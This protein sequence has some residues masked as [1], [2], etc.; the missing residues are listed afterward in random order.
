MT[1]FRF[2]VVTLVVLGLGGA[3]SRRETTST[4]STQSPSEAP[5]FAELSA[6]SVGP[7]GRIVDKEGRDVLLR[8]VNITSLGDYYQ[9]DPDNPPTIALTDEDWTQME[10]YGVSVVRL[11]IHWSLIEPTRGN[12]D[13]SYLDRISQAVDAAQAH[14]IYTV[15]DMHQDAYTATI[16]TPPGQTCPSG[17]KPAVGWD[18]APAWAT[19]TDG[20]STCTPDERNAS[21]A[22]RAAWNHFWENSRGIRDRFV[23]AWGAVAQR[24]AGRTEVAGYDV[25][26]EPE[27]S[28]PA[29]ELTPLYDALVKDSV[30]AIRSAEAA[31]GPPHL[32]FVEP[33]IPAGDQSFGLV[34]PDPKRIGVE[35]TNIVSAPHNYAESIPVASLSMDA[36]GF[37]AFATNIALG[38]GL[39]TWFGE[40]GFWDTSTDTLAKIRRYATMEDKFKLGGAWWQWRQPCGDPHSLGDTR[41]TIDG[42]THLHHLDCPG[43]RHDRPTTEFVQA[44]SRAYPRKTPGSIVSISSDYELGTFDLQATAT[45]PGQILEVWTPTAS[46]THHVTG[47]GIGAINERQ[48]GNGRILTA[49]VTAA[50]SY[51]LH[52]TRAS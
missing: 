13:A 51:E 26:N 34:I 22:V 2:V 28:R 17:T 9:G 11:I 27:V 6:L 41:R 18:G 24:F 38:F 46:G 40:Y 19:L 52:I 30:A 20:A 8:G 31:T 44:L 1:H 15:I 37:A 45:Q 23:A 14:G 25:L 36:D 50:G 3:C 29:A 21:P 32:I 48:V 5:A 4:P 47:T 16:S 10:G 43:D 39:P 7:G 42:I 12:I 49:T 33:A 35:P